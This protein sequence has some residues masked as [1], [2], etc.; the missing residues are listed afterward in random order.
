MKGGSKK[1]KRPFL[2]LEVLIAFALVA[3]CA[4]PLMYPHVAMVKEQRNFVRKVELDHLVNLM[5]GNIVQ[6][7]YTNS[8]PWSQLLHHPFVVDESLLQEINYTAPFPYKGSYTFTVC[9]KKPKKKMAPYSLYLLT[10]TFQ[11]LPDEFRNSDAKIQEKHTLEYTYR[12]F[13]VRDLREHTRSG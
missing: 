11:F 2:L 9:K 1:I 10:L 3:I 8:L 12:I 7:M 13:A 5:Y 4:L 6:K